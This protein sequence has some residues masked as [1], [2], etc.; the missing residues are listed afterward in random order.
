MYKIFC[1][2][3]L[4]FISNILFAN[5]L[6]TYD[7][8]YLNKLDQNKDAERIWDE[9]HFVSSLQGI[10]NKD[11]PN[12]YIFFVGDSFGDDL[13]GSVDRLW[14][15]RASAKGE[16]L[17]DY[18]LQS[19]N[20]LDELIKCFRKNIKG[21][22]VYDGS[23]PATSNV[24]STIAGVEN[25]ACIRY[26]P[27][28]TSLYYHLTMEL[29]IPVKK[30]LVNKDGTSKFTGVGLIPD[31]KQKST[32]SSKCDAYIWA[33]AL[34]LDTGKCNPSILGYYI[35]SYWIK[36]NWGRLS[37]STVTNQDFIISKK[38]FVFDLSTW[39]DETHVDDINQKL[40]VDF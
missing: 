28:K 8:T 37:N 15:E 30:W 29:N 34:Y 21:L 10:V 9:M 39:E 23:V 31:I 26:D 20:G 12:L 5:I 1:V 27:S 19:I 7:L 33:K 2:L 32:G 4:L 14:L 6:K 24:A 18:S 11:S 3:V 13:S 38:G 17:A 16:W 25:L 40:G 22:V 35:D 36:S